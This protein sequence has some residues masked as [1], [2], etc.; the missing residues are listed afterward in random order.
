MPPR[1]DITAL[2]RRQELQAKKLNLRV[3]MSQDREKLRETT[4]QLRA[5]RQPR[6]K[7]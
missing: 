7:P 6:K 1:T 4:Q 5:M 2:R 3:R